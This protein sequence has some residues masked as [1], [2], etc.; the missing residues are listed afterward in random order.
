MIETEGE[1]DIE[2]MIETGREREQAAITLAEYF[3]KKLPYY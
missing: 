3:C 2:R 1:R